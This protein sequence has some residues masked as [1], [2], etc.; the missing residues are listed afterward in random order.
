[1][2]REELAEW[3]RDFPL[4]RRDI[5]IEESV[6]RLRD[7][8]AFLAANRAEIDAFQAHRQLAF[9]AERAAWERDGEFVRIEALSAAPAAEATSAR[10]IAP[11]GSD[12]VEAPLGGSLWKMRVKVGDHVAKGDVIAVIEA[13]KA[14]CAVHSP[15]AGEV[16]GVYIE[17]NQPV[18]PGAALI[19]LAAG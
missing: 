17:E 18:A 3:R 16:T 10:I 1:V 6:F 5:Q 7:H 14:E 11:A 19:A 12:L 8:R 15:A 9:D 2:S 4:G 13:M